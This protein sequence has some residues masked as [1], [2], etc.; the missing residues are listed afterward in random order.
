MF[1]AAALALLALATPAIVTPAGAHPHV[2]VDMQ[3]SVVMNSQGLIE[4]FDVEWTFDDAYAQ[5]A[6]EGLDLDGDGTY[7]STEL[8]PL[9]NENIA[10]LK[11]FEYFTVMRLKGERLPIADVTKFGQIFANGKLTLYFR[12]PLRQPADPKSGKFMVKVYDPEFFIAFDYA[13]DA[14]VGVDGVLPATCAIDLQPLK[15]DAELDQTR[16]MLSTKDKDWKPDTQ[17]E[18]GAMFAQPVTVT[19]GS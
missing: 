11:E 19:C 18:F 7:S 5:T 3:S 2:I 10:S 12:V 17:E 9:T 4:G 16:E 8:Q 13:E 14:T 1:R 15:S 6:I